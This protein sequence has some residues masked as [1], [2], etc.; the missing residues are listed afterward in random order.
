MSVGIDVGTRT[1]KVVEL[2]KFG[3]KY[4]LK[5]SGVIG[6]TGV[7][8]DKLNDEKDFVPIVEALKKLYKEAKIYDKKVSISLPEFQ[9]FTRTVSLPQV[10]HQEVSSAVEWGP[11]QYVPIPLSEAILQHQILERRD[12]NTPPDVLVLLVAAQK[13]LV[14]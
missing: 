13:N 12:D 6:Y 8:P 1:I 3:D 10:T 7:D 5:A 11:E 14:E 4:K 9:V 2:T